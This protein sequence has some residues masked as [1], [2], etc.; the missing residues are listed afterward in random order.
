MKTVL[1]AFFNNDRIYL[2]LLEQTLKG[3]LLSQIES[4][5]HCFD[6]DNPEDDLSLLAAQELEIALSDMPLELVNSISITIAAENALVTQIPGKANM[7]KDDLRELVN[8]EIRQTYKL[9]EYENFFSYLLPLLPKRDGKMMM[10]AVMINKS[11]INMCKSL[12]SAVNQPIDSIEIAQLNAHNAFIYNYPELVQSTVAIIG[13]QKQFVDISI[14]NQGMPVYYGVASMNSQSELGA[15]CSAEMLKMK[16][17]Y[18][19]SLDSV[20][21]FGL[22]LTKDLLSEIKSA[23]TEIV[24]VVNRMNAFRMIEGK[25]DIR[26]REYSSRTAHIFPPCV[27]GAIPPYVNRIVISE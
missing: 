5:E 26:N 3:L 23:V 10:L 18:V 7:S 19:T 16:R 2:A 22:G 24:P 1:S 15:I 14:L 27:G 9:F 4:T 21:V 13:V 11:T 17:E 8:L 6:L 20:Y 12:L 25:L